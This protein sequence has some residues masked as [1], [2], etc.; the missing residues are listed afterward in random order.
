[1][2]GGL[3]PTYS[4]MT[5]ALES[6]RLECTALLSAFSVEGKLSKDR[7]PA[8]PKKIDPTS[9]S[10]SMFSLLSA[11]QAVGP[12]FDSLAGLLSKHAQKNVLPSL[13][14]RQRKVIA[15]LGYYAILKER[16]DT[17]VSASIAGALIAL[18]K[19]PAKLGPVI[20]AVMDS[21]RREENEILQSRSAR[22]VA[23]FVQFCASPDFTGKVN[24]C[25]KV[26]RNLFTFLCQDT[27]LTPVF[28]Q[29]QA[30]EGVLTLKEEQHRQKK[31]DAGRNRKIDAVADESEADI[32]MRVTRRG[33]QET[34]DALC[35]T[36]GKQVLD[37][38]PRLWE[39]ISGA[40]V[41]FFSDSERRIRA[42]RRDSRSAVSL[43]GQDQLLVDGT[44]GQDVVDCLSS[45]RLILPKLDVS[46]HPRIMTLFPSL[47]RAL[48]SS[49][50]VVRQSAA[51]CLAVIC[52]VMTETAMK[53]IVDDVV[54]LIGDAR[55]VYARQGA[56]EA[57]HREPPFTSSV[58]D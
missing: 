7:I 35:D 47:V 48:Q 33:A 58:E 37:D 42:L 13:R 17:Q 27:S 40:I 54:P 57:V 45:L 31:E 38:V 12:T 10:S 28:A 32:A 11:Q 15:S 46:L 41:R 36:F 6:I 25:D 1:M 44:N 26:V 14:E 2:E 16:Y 34:F 43:E 55:R 5:T 49:Y 18:R 20:K 50:A 52:D 53:V 51:K 8:L 30:A 56:V 19:M 3:P 4:E 39:G 29:L 22:A 23:A 21:V 9:S 24:P